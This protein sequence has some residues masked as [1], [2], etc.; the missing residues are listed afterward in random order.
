MKVLVLG[1]SYLQSDFI[2]TA[3]ELGYEVI[4][5][6]MD[7]N[8]YAANTKNI[9][10]IKVNISD[11]SSVEKVFLDHNC[12]LIVGPVTEI[13][14]RTAC[15]IAS[16]HNLIYNSP[17]AVK[18]TTDKQYMRKKLNKFEH[19]KIKTRPFSSKEKVLS[20][21]HFPF[22]IKPSESSASRGVILIRNEEEFDLGFNEA[23]EFCKSP[24]DILVEEYLI[25]EQY[26]I[27]TI[28][29]NGKHY[30]L[31]LTKEVLSGAPYFMERMDIV[32]ITENSR[33]RENVQ[34]YVDALLNSLDIT[35]GPCHIEVKIN[36]GKIHLIEIASR[37][38]LLRD[39]LLKCCGGA[40]YNRL[41]IKAYSG[42]NIESEDVVPPSINAF[43]GIIAYPSDFKVYQQ[44]KKDEQIFD[45]FFNGKDMRG[46]PKRLT[47]AVGYF[48][49]RS[50]NTTDFEQYSLQL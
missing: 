18:A 36:K 4:V 30:V 13:G 1:G 50:E 7:D 12:N 37:S 42:E 31:A 14:N 44:C 22:I 21:F 46:K 45:D 29:S 28:S 33:L 25:G 10:F 26:S 9:T 6:D 40:D 17:K 27:E 49:V 38:G 5:L 19:E 47:D 8:C 15:E 16:K 39:R 43:L 24:S 48:F 34:N 23:L 41:I 32:D 20:E 3:L 11:V 35:V 2:Y